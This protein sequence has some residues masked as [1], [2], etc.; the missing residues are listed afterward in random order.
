MSTISFPKTNFTLTLDT[1]PVVTSPIRTL[2]IGQ[3]NT[4]VTPTQP[5]IKN[6][7]SGQENNLF[8]DNSQLSIALKEYRRYDTVNVVDAMQLAEDASAVA[9]Q[10]RI[11]TT[12][13][14]SFQGGSI[15]FA[16][17]S[18]IF[19]LITLNVNTNDTSITLAQQ[20]YNKLLTLSQTVPYTF[21]Y[22]STDNFITVTASSG[23]GWGN[24]LYMETLDTLEGVFVAMTTEVVGGG[25]AVIPQSNL[26][27]ISTI[28]YQTIILGLPSDTNLLKLKLFMD[29]RFNTQTGVVEDGLVVTTQTTT[30]TNAIAA[31]APIPSF[32]MYFC[33]N[34]Q[35][36]ENVANTDYGIP[37]AVRDNDFIL[38][39]YLGAERNLR[40]TP[41]VSIP[42]LLVGPLLASNTDGGP[43][44]AAV[45]YANTPIYTIAPCEV[46]KNWSY[47]EQNTL[48]NAGVS[49]VGNNMQN[50]QLIMGQWVTTYLPRVFVNEIDTASIIR[51]FF[52]SNNQNRYLQATLTTGASNSP[53]VVN[54]DMFNAY[55]I[56]LYTQLTKSPYYLVPAGRSSYQAFSSNLKTS[57]DL[58][59]GIIETSMLVPINSQVRGINGA[60][61]ISFSLST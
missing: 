51:E 41:N 35:V 38:A 54:V 46:G 59:N 47:D 16:F 28:R 43:R 6:V 8:G 4:G 15:R 30:L 13:V 33:A 55:Q 20:L 32:S 49:F 1:P 22:V 27:D 58:A 57:I 24:S 52:V 17:R 44:I 19:G 60:I 34:K 53:S 5:I 48:N 40:L 42:Q 9:A 2:I 36:T 7:Q 23:G 29:S 39:S 61:K 31:V 12:I 45:P 11:T 26:D 37:G 50:T 10:F 25:D 18:V 14:P 3:L 21:T 56:T